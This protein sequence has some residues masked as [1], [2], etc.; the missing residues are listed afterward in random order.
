MYI[1]DAAMI[2]I[3]VSS[4]GLLVSLLIIYFLV[5]FLL[6]KYVYNK[7]RVIYKFIHD[8]KVKNSLKNAN[9]NT[10]NSLDEVNKEVMK[11][12]SDT[13]KRI[14]S[15][16]TLAEYRKNF[17]GNVSHEL[18]TPIFSLQGYLHTL[19]DGGIYDE[20]I[21]IKYISKAAENADR[22]QHIVEDLES[23]GNMESGKKE[24]NIVKFDIYEL[25][26]DVFADQRRA[27]KKQNVNLK[28]GSSAEL[29]LYV[30][31]DVEAIR[32]V[33]NNLVT[34]TLKYGEEGGVT[35]ISIYDMHKNIL[36]EVSDDGIGIEDQHIEHLFDRFYRVDS[37]RSRLKGGSGLGL[38]IVKHIVESHNQTINVRSTVGEGSTF[39]FT[40]EK[41]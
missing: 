21:N 11:W 30:R 12:A 35:E 5:Y 31:G 2:N 26:K 41:A 32:Q 20:N 9:T 29:P 7:L 6:N 18:K 22:L 8:S 36:V 23:I 34:N 24:L 1:L 10:I 13:Q 3:L 15:L 37:S 16:Q 14:E 25:I 33:L 38:S 4:L 39:G 27:A 17:V 40:L 28:I 19:L